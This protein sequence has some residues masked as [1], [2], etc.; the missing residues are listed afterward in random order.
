[1]VRIP[2][3][4]LF[5]SKNAVGKLHLLP[6]TITQFSMPQNFKNVAINSQ[7]YLVFFT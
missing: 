4:V 2:K 5:K 3:L 6:Q 1:M 7:N